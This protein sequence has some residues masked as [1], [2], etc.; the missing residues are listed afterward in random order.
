MMTV[1]DALEIAAENLANNRWV[2][3]EPRV[4]KLVR[5]FYRSQL[6]LSEGGGEQVLQNAAGTIVAK[7]YDRFV[8]GDYGAYVE[9]NSDQ[10]IKDHIRPKWP[11]E[12][13]RPVKYLWLE[14]KDNEKTKVYYQKGK[15][16]YADYKIGM[17]YIDCRD[18][19]L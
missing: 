13:K 17:Y 7:G 4:R 14:T 3:L 18:L 10:I 15:V 9:I 8:V 1:D 11:G 2:P 12:P 5:D 19:I 16:G 6:K